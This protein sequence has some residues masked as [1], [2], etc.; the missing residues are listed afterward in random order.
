MIMIVEDILLLIVF[1][2]AFLWAVWIYLN[3]E[4]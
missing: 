4:F 2:A 3:R 1:I